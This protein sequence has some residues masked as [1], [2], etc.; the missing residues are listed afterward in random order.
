[1]P[2]LARPP[3][4]VQGYSG[5]LYRC[6]HPSLAPL[7]PSQPALPSRPSHALCG[8]T[9]DGSSSTDTLEV[10]KRRPARLAP[11][12]LRPSQHPPRYPPCTGKPP[13]RDKSKPLPRPFHV[14]TDL[15]PAPAPA[16]GTPGTPGTRAP[17]FTQTDDVLVSS[18]SRESRDHIYKALH[19]VVLPYAMATFPELCLRCAT[20]WLG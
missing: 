16:P 10:P 12:P 3:N 13:S 15:A 14:Q 2:P 6:G 7:Y 4:P 20:P 11:A 18:L 9:A 17:L 1:M 19:D 5:A 8:G